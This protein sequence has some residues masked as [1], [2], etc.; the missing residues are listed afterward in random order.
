MDGQLKKI[1]K[2]FLLLKA[3]SKARGN[4]LH[5]DEP[6]SPVI[7]EVNLPADTSTEDKVEI[8]AN[9]RWMGSIVNRKK[10]KKKDFLK[11]E[12]LEKEERPFR[13]GQVSTHGKYIADH[14]ENGNLVWHYHPEIAH[15]TDRFISQNK[16]KYLQRIKP[17][18]R[19]VVSDMFDH[20]LKDRNRHVV[21]AFDKVGGT[22]AIRARH[23]KSLIEGQDH[24]KLQGHGPNDISLKAVRHGLGS[25][26][27]E[28]HVMPFS[29]KTKLA[30]SEMYKSE[31]KRHLEELGHFE[32]ADWKQ[33][34]KLT[35]E[36]E[37]QPTVL[38]HY[39][40]QPGLKEI[41]PKQMGTGA[42]GSFSRRFNPSQ[43]KDFPHTSFHYIQDTPE[44]IVRGGA[45]SKYTI[46]L[47]PDT[48]LYDLSKDPEKLVHQ[49]VQENQGVW[50]YEN[51]LNKIKS[52]GYHGTWASRSENPVI[53]NTV[54]LFHPH[55][56]H[57]EEG[58]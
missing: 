36:E 48:K 29:N 5:K 44:D 15:A 58:I 53:S 3:L 16:D 37:K 10:K 52:A 54:Q 20:V 43:I 26:Y 51:V 47:D 40:R 12:P 41:D 50:N 33:S 8:A 39:S 6:A 34:Y 30:A 18:Y 45:R 7:S 56:V 27:N 42:P 17:E 13:V 4:S 35:K 14:H 46:K 28:Q 21:A 49:A 9:T 24:V 57:L 1:L 38:Y 31:M 2:S 19:P 11:S 55:P 22:P 32:K 25:N 23:L